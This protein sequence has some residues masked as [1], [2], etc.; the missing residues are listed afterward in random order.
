MATT[1]K[2][3]LKRSSVAG[4]IPDSSDLQY[5]ELAI[6][7]ADGKLYYKDDANNIN[8]FID[9]ARV[10]AI[11]DAVE[12]VA[13]AQLDSGEVSTLVDS[14]YVQARVPLSYLEGL[15]DSA[16]IQA[17]QDFAYSSLTGAP[18]LLDS[19]DVTNIVDSAYIQARQVD[20]Y[21]DS[22]FITG[23][24][25]SAYVQARQLDS[26]ATAT[27]ALNA[28]KLNNQVASYYL[29]YNNLS[30]KPTIL[31]TVDVSNII[32][33][34]VDKAFVDALNVDADTLDGYQAQYFIDKID[35]N[36]AAMLDSAEAIALIDSAYVQARQSTYT[37]FDTD[38]AAKTT[39]DLTE[40]NNLYYTKARAD[41]DI[42][43]SLNDSGNT[44]NITINNTIEDKVDSAYVLARVNEAPFIDSAE[45]IALIDSAYVRARVRTNQDLRTTD[46]VTF[47][48]ITGDSAALGQVSFSTTWNDSHIPFEE[49]AVWYDPHHKNLNYYT[50]F[51]HPIELGMQIIERVYNNNAYTILKGQ[52]LY[53]S[54][55]RTNEAGQESPTVGLANATESTKYNVQGLAA[56]D[57]PQNSYGQIVVAGVIDGF[58]TSGLTAGLNFFAGL[59]DGAVQNAPPTYPNY[60]MCL[61]WVIKSDSSEGKVIINQQN[62]S[63]NTFRVQGDTHIGDDLVVDGNLTVNGTQTVTSTANVQIGG[64]IQYL[65][66][67]DTIGEG[68]TTFVG[69]GLDDAFFSGHYSGDSSTKSFFVKIDATGETDTF[70]WGF[71]SSVGTEA[72]GIAITGAAQTLDSAYGISITFGATTGHTTGDKWTGTAT[73]TNVDTGFFTNRNTGDAGDGYTHLGLYYDV[74]QN[75]WTFVSEYE[76]EPENPINRSHASFAYGD[77]RGKDFYGTTFNGNLTGNVTGTVSD[78]SNHSTTDLIEGSNLYYTTARHDSDTLAQVDAAYV[79]AR[80]TVYSTVN[81]TDSAFVTGLPVSTFTNDA[82]YLDS[83][84][85]QGVIDA[86][87][88]Q[89]NQT[90]Y[91]NVSEFTNDANYLDS[92]TVQGVIDATYIQANQT[93]YNTSNFTDSAY[94]TGLPVS[95]FTNDANYLDSTTATQLIDSA[96]IALRTAAG[97]DS[98]TVVNIINTEV[99]SA[100]VQSRQVSANAAPLTQKTYVFIADSG[101]ATFTGADDRGLTLA[102]VADR[103]QVYLNGLLLVDSDDYT[104]TNGTSIVLTTAADSADV[105]QVEY[106]TGNNIGID[107][108]QVQTLIDSAYIQLRQADIYRDSGFVT[109]IVTASY[110]QANQTTYNTS[111]FTDSAYVTGLPVS[112]FTN[113]ANYL[114]STTVQGVI[115]A[116]YIQ[117]NQTTYNTSDFTDS[118]FVTGLPVST[119]TNDAN[120]LDS[121][122]ATQLI[123]SSYIE[124]RRPAE[125][126]FSVA[127]DGSN[128]TFTGDGFSSSANNP[129]LYL[130]RGKTYKFADISGSHPLEIRLSAGGSAYSDGVT[131]NG[132]SGTVL[133]TVDMDA[134]NTLVYQC[135]VHS[136]MVGDI[137]ILDNNSFTDSAEVIK[138]ITANAIDSGV[139]LQLLLDSSEVVNLIDSAY[140]NL[141]VDAT[142][143]DSIGAIGNVNAVGATEGQILKF[144]SASQTFILATDA[145]G[146]AGGGLDSA[147]II[148]LID[149]AYVQA[150]EAAGGSGTVDSADIIAIVDSAYVQARQITD[151]SGSY[152]QTFFRYT[153]DSGQTVI[154]GT[155]GFGQTLDYVSGQVDVFLNGILLVDSADYTQTNSS[156]ITIGTALD[157]GDEISILYRRG[158][159][160]TPNVVVYEYTA[161]AGQATFSGTAANGKTLAYTA[162]AVQVFVNGILLKASED[163]TATDGTSVVL[164]TSAS[165]NDDVAI[166]A[167]AAPHAKATS[168]TFTADSGQTT[169]NGLDDRGTTLAYEP[170]NSIV[171][172]NGIAL[173]DSG[174][175]TASN[176][177]SIVLTSAANLNDELKVVSFGSVTTTQSSNNWTEA[178]TSIKISPNEKKFI[179]CSDS[180]VTLSIQDSGSNVSMGDEIRIIDGYGNAAN[181]NITLTSTKKILGSDSDFIIDINRAGVNFV[182]YN[183]SNGWVLI[184]N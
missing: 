86:A 134:P 31:D 175:Y 107:S 85:V 41:S 23:I 184:E 99:D 88:I 83:T 38:F 93:T 161:T 89:A 82:N 182:Y 133:F 97:T 32:T 123:D 76:P 138:L 33:T 40:G 57:I 136:G 46:D 119:F 135:T 1:P 177:T 126:I 75:E 101:Q 68:G 171:F 78:I 153:A 19:A 60:P 39:T 64:N 13:Q 122:T 169:F 17:R 163:Y 4:R 73:A 144:D 95:T 10:Q 121:T 147:A 12:V 148:N 102:Y 132:G 106:I 139:A 98:A 146:G 35:S 103:V 15:I 58:N 59:T 74:S 114:D 2:V 6:N 43:A 53:Y 173:N 63:V 8:A 50:D 42:A 34:D 125:T 151:I 92:T 160:V 183:E 28:N 104:A 108:A 56:E 111:D 110:I 96:Y 150:R 174:D 180:A 115:D 149:S 62:H 47:A 52:P 37:N 109:G 80:Q 129:T 176:S 117:A 66:G 45:A 156:T 70:E 158:T 54:G 167:Y 90:T 84:T 9:S 127:G 157:S 118:A 61:G 105:L 21:R 16:Y 55:N 77:V 137:V 166:A 140:I 159:F 145:T 25:D 79:Q 3:L 30:N 27:T 142:V 20:I 172:L 72:T 29:N 18:D 26:A 36:T 112:T 143:I 100:Y 91:S 11:A 14:A 116:T 141:R 154:T 130:T 44:V 5:G 179:D 87:Y 128:Y 181:N 94:V 120:Y 71:D 124:T 7:F 165:L 168:F 65:N 81:F 155:D 164:N 113:D 152:T 67:G 48:K 131:N 51:D 22:G 162:G 69:T 24:I 49:G 178:T 170:N